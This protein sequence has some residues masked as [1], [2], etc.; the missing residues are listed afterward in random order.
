MIEKSQSNPFARKSTMSP[1]NQTKENSPSLTGSTPPQ[2][3]PESGRPQIPLLGAI[4]ALGLP[5]TKS[6]WLSVVMWPGLPEFP[7]DPELVAMIPE[8]LPGELPKSRDEMW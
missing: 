3:N 4:R 5:E 1:S 8:Q 6:S 2:E 7:L